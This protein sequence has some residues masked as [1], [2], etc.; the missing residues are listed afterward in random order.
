MGCPS[1]EVSAASVNVHCILG[2]ARNICQCFLGFGAIALEGIV[3]AITGDVTVVLLWK[4]ALT[5]TAIS[6]Q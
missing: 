5:L 1:E 4:L 3:P 2:L 6:L